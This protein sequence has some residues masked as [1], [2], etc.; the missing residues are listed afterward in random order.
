MYKE[1]VV[2]GNPFDMVLLKLRFV[3]PDNEIHETC[4]CL[5]KAQFIYDPK[6]VFIISYF[7][8]L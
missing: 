5:H 2:K 6:Y 7:F 4:F 3:F 1:T 8:N